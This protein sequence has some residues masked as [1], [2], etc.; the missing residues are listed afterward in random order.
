MN[1]LMSIIMHHN[2]VITPFYVHLVL[3]FIK[4]TPESPFI[5]LYLRFL[6]HQ[7]FYYVIIL[8][9]LLFTFI[10]QFL[11]IYSGFVIIASIFVYFALIFNPLVF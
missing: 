7:I 1:N 9:I 5:A 3:L 2:S 8:C 11:I 10:I 4:L 6:F